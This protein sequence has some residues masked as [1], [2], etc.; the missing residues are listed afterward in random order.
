MSAPVSPAACSAA[1]TEGDAP[2]VAAAPASMLARSVIPAQLLSANTCTDVTA[3]RTLGSIAVVVMVWV[4]RVSQLT[5]ASDELAAELALDNS[6]LTSELALD[7]ALEALLTAE[8]RSEL[9]LETAPDGSL[10]PTLALTS[11]LTLALTSWALA[12]VA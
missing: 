11:A 12:A 5:P 10:T 1:V 4:S 8:L 3:A 6:P 9:A 2:I 7:S